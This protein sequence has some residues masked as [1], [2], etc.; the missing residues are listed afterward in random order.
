MREDWHA[1]GILVL[2]IK[3]IQSIG[4]TTQVKVWV[5]DPE[6]REDWHAQG[7]PRAQGYV[8]ERELITQKERPCEVQIGYGHS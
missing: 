8:D 1:Q 6:V 3:P 7:Q 4:R 2:Y 5:T